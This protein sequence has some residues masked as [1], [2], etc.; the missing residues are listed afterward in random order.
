ME[1]LAEI[2]K[3]LKERS[4]FPETKGCMISDW[5][6]YYS[7]R[8]LLVQIQQ[9]KHQNSKWNLLKVNNLSLLLTLTD[10]TC[11]SGVSFVNTEQVNTRWFTCCML[12]KLT[13]RS[14]NFEI[15]KWRF[16]SKWHCNRKA[17][18][19]PYLKHLCWMELF[20]EIVHSF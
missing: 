19:K 2:L 14:G 18:L 3:L 1:K 6:Q 9:W 13:L 12:L 17:Y 20:P 10:F 4:D 8:Y 11:Y 16:L 7:S 5:C 15:L